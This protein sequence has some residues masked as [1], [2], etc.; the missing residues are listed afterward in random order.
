M[1]LWIIHKQWVKPL[2]TISNL[3]KVEI[4]VERGADDVVKIYEDVCWIERVLV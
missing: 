2:D 3:N 1:K 4:L